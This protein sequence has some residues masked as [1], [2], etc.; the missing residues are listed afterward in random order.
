M[1]D[2]GPVVEEISETE[3]LLDSLADIEEVDDLPAAP[4]DWPEYDLPEPEGYMPPE[5]LSDLP[6]SEEDFT[7]H[8]KPGHEHPDNL[9]G[10]PLTEGRPP[11]LK[12]QFPEGGSRGGPERG[13]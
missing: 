1:D 12:P 7:V 4:E 2:A 13:F 11:D 3:E 8:P 10:E 5:T 9:E 6:E